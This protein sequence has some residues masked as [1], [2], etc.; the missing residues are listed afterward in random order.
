MILNLVNS[1]MGK[2]EV[3]LDRRYSNRL[4]RN[5]HIHHHGGIPMVLHGPCGAAPYH[6]T[7][8]AREVACRVR[9]STENADCAFDSEELEKV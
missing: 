4:G 8:H 2:R 1:H 9:T 6:M 7:D 3:S 5:S